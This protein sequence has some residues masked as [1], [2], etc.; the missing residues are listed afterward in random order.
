MAQTGAGI[1]GLRLR[2]GERVIFVARPH[3]L[4]IIPWAIFIIPYLRWKSWY[5][6]LTNQRIIQ[7]Y[8]IFMKQHR[9]IEFDKVTD[10]AG[11]YTGLIARLFGIGNVQIET[12]GSSQPMLLGYLPRPMEHADQIMHEMEQ[13]KKEV[14]E[15]KMRKMAEMVA[16][17][18]G[19]AAAAPG[20]APAAAPLQPE[21]LQPEPAN[22]VK[23]P[24]C[25]QAYT[26]TQP[27]NYSCKQCGAKF[28]VGE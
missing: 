23:C 5:N 12:A 26:I 11:G 14:E 6:V 24:S 4:S 8:G 18:Q 17:S 2:E 3:V 16:Q 22:Q 9:A 15:E 20:P 28:K 27:G 21:P 19:G 25:G 7:M 1:P 13:H 10:V